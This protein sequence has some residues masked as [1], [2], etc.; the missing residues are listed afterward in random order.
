MKIIAVVVSGETQ[1][2]LIDENTIV[3]QA[4]TAGINPFYH[5]RREIS[6]LI[7]LQLPEA[8][9]KRRWEHIYFYGAG[10]NNAEKRKNIEN[11]L[12]AQFRTPVTIHT[13]LLGVARS[14]FGDNSGIACILGAISNSGLYNGTD[15]IQNVRPLGYVLGDEGS[16]AYFGKT[17]L[18]DY[19]KG[20][21][22]KS[23]R[24]AFSDA[25][26]V[27]VDMIMDDVYLKPSPERTLV[28]YSRFLQEHINNEYVFHLIYTGFMKFFTRN[29]SA[30][31]HGAY[32]ISFIGD[33][34]VQYESILR[35]VATDFGTSICDVH[36]SPLQGLLKYHSTH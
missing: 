17:F 14:L 18:S 32:P 20:I 34:A 29:V 9:F 36:L 22:P 30:Y 8:F 12:V 31:D 24:D 10:C 23:I 16:G 6:H 11:S 35:R 26:G 28:Y 33:I 25:Y 19:L 27:T 7:R 13:N 15:I 21:A 3:E 2:I 4:V 1:W 5:S